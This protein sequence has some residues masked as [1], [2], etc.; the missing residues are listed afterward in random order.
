MDSYWNVFHLDKSICI[1]KNLYVKNVGGET[2]QIILIS[3]G[4]LIGRQILKFSPPIAFILIAAPLIKYIF[5]L[6]FVYV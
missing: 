1:G 5:S 6:K 3:D 4:K 2:S